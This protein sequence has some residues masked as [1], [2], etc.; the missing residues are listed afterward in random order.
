MRASPLISWLDM[1][2][3]VRGHLKV[4]AFAGAATKTRAITEVIAERAPFEGASSRFCH[5]I[6]S[7]FHV[8][9]KSYVLDIT[10]FLQHALKC[11]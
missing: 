1:D 3:R 11:Q 6:T 9:M 4:V 10:T 5:E 8:N 2:L 7:P